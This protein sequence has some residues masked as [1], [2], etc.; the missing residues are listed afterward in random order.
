MA[1]QRHGVLGN[2][3]RDLTRPNG[4]LADE[5]ADESRGDS[6]TSKSQ[7]R[8]RRRPEIKEKG[9]GRNLKI[10]DTVFRR[11]ELDATSAGG[12]TQ[13]SSRGFLT[14]NFPGISRSS[15]ATRSPRPS[16]QA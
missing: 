4:E 13:N 3:V 11:L 8:R 5:Q 16:D 10:P 2:V 7:T 15:S 14:D 6:L 1:N 9:K 12:I